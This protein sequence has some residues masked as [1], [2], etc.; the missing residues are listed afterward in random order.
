[1]AKAVR[2]SGPKRISLRHGQIPVIAVLMETSRA[3]GRGVI[4]GISNYA[5]AHGPWNLNITPGDFNQ[6]LPPAEMWHVD[7]IIGRMV[8]HQVLQEAQAR[9]VPIVCVDPSF[10]QESIY[11]KTDQAAVSQLAF[12][13]LRDAGFRQFAF[14][15]LNTYWG[16][17]RHKHFRHC[18]H[19]AGMELHSFEFDDRGGKSLEFQ[20]AHWLEHLPKP[21]GLMAQDDL[22]AHEAINLCR[23][24]GIKVPEQVAIIGV[25]NDELV[26]D[27]SSPTL[28]S[29]ELNCQRIGFDAAKALDSLLAGHDP[30][31]NMLLA[32]L[33]VVPRESTDTVGLGDPVVAE[34]RRFIRAHISEPINVADLARKVLVSRRVLE[35]RF[36]KVLQ[37]SPHE[38][39]LQSRLARARELLISTDMKLLAIAA[40]VGFAST[41][42][43]HQV[44]QRELRQTPGEFRAANR[45]FA[46]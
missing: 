25:D 26:C 5:K 29:I 33:R 37:R 15:S 43:M 39:I 40:E 28:S 42:Y 31:P 14:Y 38:E 24:V 41:Q 12:N 21:V 34:A 19:A 30:G 46:R 32:P 8:S 45:P 2:K 10:E 16:R 17:E 27:L 44:F 18:V 4:C 13:H 11:V 35:M 7:A 3:F 6:R 20:S 22:L 1:M 36:E 9:N 23:F